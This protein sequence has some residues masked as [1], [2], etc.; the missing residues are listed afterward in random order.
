MNRRDVYEQIDKERDYQESLTTTVFRHN[1]ADRSVP[2]EIVMMTTYL[3]HAVHEFTDYC[4]DEKALH[5]IRKIVAL[6]VRCL[7]NHGCPERLK[8]K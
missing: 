8:E 1:E 6:G 3:N 4:G 2:A 5:Q 7:E